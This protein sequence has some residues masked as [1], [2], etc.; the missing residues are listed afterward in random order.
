LNAVR[1]LKHLAPFFTFFLS[2]TRSVKFSSGLLEVG[3]I[4]PLTYPVGN[5]IAFPW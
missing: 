4:N 5:G 1:L 2:H 3:N